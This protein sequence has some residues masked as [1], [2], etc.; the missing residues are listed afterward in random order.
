M[1]QAQMGDT[2]AFSQLYDLTY[3]RLLAFLLRKTTGDRPLSED[4]VSETFCKA[5]KALQTFKPQPDRPVI[6]WLYRIADNELK[7][8]W[9]KQNRY[10]FEAL[11]DHPELRCDRPTAFDHVVQAEQQTQVRGALQQLSDSDRTL[12]EQHYFQYTSVSDLAVRLDVTVSAVKVRLHR[13]RKKLRQQ[14]S[15]L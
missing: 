11:E 14:L 7:L 4:L 8:Y 9:R 1:K 15:H 13:A 5:L 6:A 12:L 3:D 2:E 10:R